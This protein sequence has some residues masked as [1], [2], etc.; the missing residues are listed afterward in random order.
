M[1]FGCPVS[2]IKIPERD[3]QRWLKYRDQRLFPSDRIVLHLAQISFWLASAQGVQNAK[4]SDFVLERQEEDPWTD[5][6][7]ESAR[8]FFDFKPA[9]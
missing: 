4:I 3:F 1:E 8:K 6:P 2:E 9:K 7:A 5:D